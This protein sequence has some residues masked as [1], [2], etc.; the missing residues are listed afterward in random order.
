MASPS[1]SSRLQVPTP[2]YRCSRPDYQPEVAP[3]SAGVATDIKTDVT[4]APTAISVQRYPPMVVEHLPDWVGHFKKLSQRLCH[5]PNARS[6]GKDVHFLSRSEEGYCTVKRY[7]TV[8]SEGSPAAFPL[9]GWTTWKKMNCAVYMKFKS[10]WSAWDCN[11]RLAGTGGSTVM[12]PVLGV[13]PR[14]DALSSPAAMCSLRRRILCG[15]LSTSK[16]A[17]QRVTYANC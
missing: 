16:R 8:A 2:A 3:A 15:G 9:C 5:A 4:T 6:F 12:S 11:Q 13:G 7:L 17:G 1:P 10:C 14:L